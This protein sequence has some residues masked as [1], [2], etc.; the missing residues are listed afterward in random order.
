MAFSSVLEFQEKVKKDDFEIIEQNM[1]TLVTK[2]ARKA[3]TLILNALNTENLKK[4]LSMLR[5]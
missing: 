5:K 3:N 2:T 4:R 1:R